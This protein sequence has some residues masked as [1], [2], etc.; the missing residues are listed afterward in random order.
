[1][2]AG[3]SIRLCWLRT[4]RMSLGFTVWQAG[5]GSEQGRYADRA[6]R[7]GRQPHRVLREGKAPGRLQLAGRPPPSWGLSDTLSIRSIGRL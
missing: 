6:S 4:C 2:P 1:M 5:C 7:Q 3:D